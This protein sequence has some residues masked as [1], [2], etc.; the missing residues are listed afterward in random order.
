VRTVRELRDRGWFVVFADRF[1]VCGAGVEP[2]PVMT[3]QDRTGGSFADGEVE[4]A[5]GAGSYAIVAGLLSLPTDSQCA[6]R[7]SSRRPS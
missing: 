5:D 3:A 6:V 2:S 7:V 1:A 4:G